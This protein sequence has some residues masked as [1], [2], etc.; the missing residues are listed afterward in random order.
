MT[1]SN[2]MLMR[3]IISQ[4]EQLGVNIT[5]SNSQS[6]KKR[7]VAHILFKEKVNSGFLLGHYLLTPNVCFECRMVDG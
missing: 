6:Q 7:Q 3:F 2:R 5:S 1:F 4:K